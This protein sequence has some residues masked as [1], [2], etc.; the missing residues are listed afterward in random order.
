LVSG[1][2]NTKN[3]ILSLM[4]VLILIG[5]MATILISSAETVTDELIF[6]ENGTAQKS[7][8]NVCHTVISSEILKP[9]GYN[10]TSQLPEKLFVQIIRSY[11]EL[12]YQGPDGDYY[13]NITPDSP[14]AAV[15]LIGT[16]YICAEEGYV[17]LTNPPSSTETFAETSNVANQNESTMK[18]MTLL[19]QR[20]CLVFAVTD[21]PG[22]AKDL[23]WVQ[24][25][26]DALKSNII[27]T[28]AYDYWAFITNNSCTWSNIYNWTTW[29]CMNYKNVDIYWFGHGYLDTGVHSFVSYDAVFTNGTINPAKCY[30]TSDFTSGTYDYSTLRF[31]VANFCWGGNFHTTFL[32]PGGSTVHN[33]GFIGT[34]T[35]ISEGYIYYYA[36]YWGYNWYATYSTSQS[37]H[38]SSDDQAAP[39][40]DTGQNSYTHYGT[41][42][43][44]R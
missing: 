3:K 33:R 12:A 11:N 31:G 1:G 4:L 21:Y 41:S 43:Y 25:G 16:D 42:M 6:K 7:M 9:L 28:N 37:A 19:N 20:A 24:Y 44:F 39:Y 14:K 8:N 5:S 34:D 26:Y 10:D 38:T 32:N 40:K 30:Y 36:S 2:K 15:N 18:P 22:S 35:E 13:C 29:A 23:T 27:Y 17:D